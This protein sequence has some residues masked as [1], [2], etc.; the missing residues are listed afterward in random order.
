MDCSAAEMK[1]ATNLLIQVKVAPSIRDTF[2]RQYGEA[3]G[4][5][6]AGQSFIC[7]KR[8]D[9]KRANYEIWFSAPETTV[10]NLEIL[11]FKPQYFQQGDFTHL[12]DDERL[13]WK[14]IRNGFRIGQQQ[15]AG[16]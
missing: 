15:L 13:F 9:G 1:K 7:E 5:R 16:V 2:S 8:R 10:R 6:P 11:G 14:L 12:I 3:T 4:S